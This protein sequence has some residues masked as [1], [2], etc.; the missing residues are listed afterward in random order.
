[1]GVAS[2]EEHQHLLQQKE[3]ES[4]REQE[5]S[6]VQMNQNPNMSL[7]EEIQYLPS[8]ERRAASNQLEFQDHTSLID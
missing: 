2:F 4:Q 5:D 7:A 3:A 6:Q 8:D 1:M